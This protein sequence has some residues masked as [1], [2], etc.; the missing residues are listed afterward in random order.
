MTVLM[1]EKPVKKTT[2]SLTKKEAKELRKINPQPAKEK[3][4]A[5]KRK[6]K[7]IRQLGEQNLPHQ[8]NCSSSSSSGSWFH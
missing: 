5:M 3:R 7:L 8:Q 2:P 4:K 1:E 6:E